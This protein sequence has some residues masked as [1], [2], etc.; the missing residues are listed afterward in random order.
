MRDLWLINEE[1]KI[2]VASLPKCGCTSMRAV[3]R[4]K[5]VD[6]EA[7]I[8]RDDLTKIAWIRDPVERLIS[9]YSFFKA[10]HENG[11]K[12]NVDREATNSWNEWVDHTLS[13]NN[14]HW[15]PQTDIVSLDGRFLP[16]I[17]YRFEE[18]AE[19]WGVHFRGLLPRLNGCVH[20]PVTPYRF[21]EIEAKYAAD[22][23]VWQFASR[24]KEV[25]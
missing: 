14:P 13:I 10:H 11:C 25:A 2:A 24:P 4:V 16:D 1:K 21:D 5:P 18:L 15:N 12:T 6:S 20:E 22:S 9:G 7:I 3:L 23:L 19:T 8:L 17:V